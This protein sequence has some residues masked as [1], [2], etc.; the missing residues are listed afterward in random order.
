MGGQGQE[1][2]VR[3]A[4]KVAVSV[5]AGCQM[6]RTGPGNCAQAW[7][8]GRGRQG[9]IRGRR[10]CSVSDHIVKCLAQVSVVAHKPE[11]VRRGGGAGQ[12]RGWGRA[13]EVRRGEG[14]EKGGWGRLFLAQTIAPPPPHTAFPAPPHPWLPSHLL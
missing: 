7:E 6:S 8:V 2:G 13:G 12:G 4:L 10:I 5:T 3:K 9:G 1:T 11:E 14:E